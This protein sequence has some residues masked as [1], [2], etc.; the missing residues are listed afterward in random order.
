MIVRISAIPKKFPTSHARVLIILA[1]V[2]CVHSEKHKVV[3]P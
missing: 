1:P 2:V 3:T